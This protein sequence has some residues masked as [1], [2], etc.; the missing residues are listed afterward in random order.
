MFIKTIALE[1]S[2]AGDIIAEDIINDFGVTLVAKDTIVNDYIKDKLAVY[3]IRSVKIYQ[4]PSDLQENF[5]ESYTEILLQTKNIFQDIVSGKTLNCKSVSSIADK[6]IDCCHENN[7]IIGCLSYI[8]NADEYTFRHSMNVAFYSMLI[9]K[10]LHLSDRKVK[11]AVKSGLL[12]DVGKIKIP[13]EILNKKGKLTKEEF[14]IIKKHTILGYEIVKDLEEIESDIKL[15]VLLHHERVDGSGYPYH[16]NSDRVNLYARIVAVADVFDAMT[17]DR[18][19]RGKSTPFD[20]FE[21]F[22]SVG[23]GIFDAQILNMFVS[24]LS[25]YLIGAKVQLSSGKTGEVV[26]I[27]LQNISYPIIKVESDYI[28]LFKAEEVKIVGMIQTD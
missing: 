23:V 19:Y 10:W 16:Y 24:K 21:M 8:Q 18:V 13:K 22:Q 25:T 28:D 5:Q 14:E 17:S 7:K 1:S 27:P 4:E 9:A 2:K 26:F 3:G 11:I 15:A 20:V 6:I 12:H